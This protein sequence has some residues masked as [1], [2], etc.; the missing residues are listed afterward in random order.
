MM[1]IDER[2]MRDPRFRTLVD[3]LEH[4]IRELSLS[5]TEI[6]EAAM[7]AC[8]HFEDSRPKRWIEYGNMVSKDDPLP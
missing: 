3:M 5:P 2:Y 1:S 7:L 6:R 4:E 8:I